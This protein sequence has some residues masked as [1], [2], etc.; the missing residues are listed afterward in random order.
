MNRAL[1]AH[2]EQVL[3][4]DVKLDIYAVMMFVKWNW[5]LREIILK[6]WHFLLRNFG[7]QFGL[8]LVLLVHQAPIVN[9]SD[10]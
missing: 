8:V 9:E 6:F 1:E 4:L 3:N 5:L 7:E 10:T 2:L